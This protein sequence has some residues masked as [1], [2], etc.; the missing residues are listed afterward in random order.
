MQGPTPVSSDVYYSG[1]YWNNRAEVLAYMNER[2]TGNPSVQWWQHLLAWRG[3]PFKRALAINCGNGWVERDLITFGVMESAVGIDFSP[4]LLATARAAATER[5]LP[6]EYIEVDINTYDF[7]LE[8]V[9]LVINFAAAHHIASIDRVFRHLARLLGP[10]GVFVSYDY[11]GPHR[12]LYPTAQWE[13]IWRANQA[14]P[15]EFRRDLHYAHVPTMLASDPT[16]AIHSELIVSTMKRYFNLPVEQYLGGGVA[17]ELLSFNAAFHDPERDAS[18]L[19]DQVLTAD[20]A[21]RALAPAANSLFAY[22][23]A[24]PGPLP[25]ASQL[26]EW[27]AAEEAREAA[28]RDR[29]GRYY[30]PTMVE[31]LYQRIYELEAAAIHGPPIH[32]VKDR[33]SPADRLARLLRRRRV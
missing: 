5:E 20:E 14:M 3:R 1:M 26:D 32:T 17:Y 31:E 19:V 2:A 29:G 8:G 15:V 28:A 18:A 22:L 23:L 33:F 7:D 13:A 10:D 6:I 11:V 27:T 24:V 16:E 30:P 25:D 9:D 4:D 21:Y 12:N